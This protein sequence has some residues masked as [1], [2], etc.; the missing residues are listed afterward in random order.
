[1]IGFEVDDLVWREHHPPQLCCCRYSS[2]DDECSE[3]Y[4]CLCIEIVVVV[5]VV[6]V[7]WLCH[8]LFLWYLHSSVRMHVYHSCY[9]RTWRGRSWLTIGWC[10]WGY[11]WGTAAIYAFSLSYVSLSRCNLHCKA[12]T[13]QYFSWNK[14]VET[15]KS[16]HLRICVS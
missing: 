11:R 12:S 5:V 6:E 16:Q 8:S 7:L 10:Q 4:C 13:V 9:D 1:M 3:I 15:E 14:T 2:L